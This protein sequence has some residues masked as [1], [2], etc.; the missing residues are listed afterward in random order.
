MTKEGLESHRKDHAEARKKAVAERKE[1]RRLCGINGREADRQKKL[2]LWA[3]RKLRRARAYGFEKDGEYLTVEFTRENGERVIAEY[4]RIGWARPP[5]EL[6]K[7]IDR[8]LNTA[9]AE[10]STVMYPYPRGARKQTPEQP[11]QAE[12]PDQTDKPA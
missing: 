6:A 9:P 3:E 4:Q 11:A 5:A 8:R 12:P 10:G 7:D 1:F 2:H